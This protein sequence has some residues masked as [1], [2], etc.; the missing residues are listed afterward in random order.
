[1]Y[2][3]SLQFYGQGITARRRE[4]VLCYL[5][6]PYYIVP[7]TTEYKAAI[8]RKRNVKDGTR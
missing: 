7:V 8:H 6:L 2:Y 5:P 3:P 4:D 1:M